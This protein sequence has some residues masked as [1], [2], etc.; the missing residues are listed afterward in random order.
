MF[1]FSERTSWFIALLIAA[2]LLG[3]SLWLQANNG[4]VPCPLCTLQRLTFFILGVLFLIGASRAWQARGWRSL[5]SLLAVAFSGI[6]V[7]LAGRQVWLQTLPPSQQGDCGVS[8]NYMLQVLPFKEAMLKAIA[9]SAECGRV[10]WQLLHLSLAQ[11]SLGFF[12]LLLFISLLQLW[13]SFMRH[14]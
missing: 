9:G 10:D 14:A 13:R 8:L 3:G 7:F 5:L 12:I 6:G 4:M 11:W 2:G 1:S